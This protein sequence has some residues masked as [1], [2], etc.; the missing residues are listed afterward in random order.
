MLE[1]CDSI[2]TSLWEHQQTTHKHE[3]FTLDVSKILLVNRTL[4]YINFGLVTTSTQYVSRI[5]ACVYLNASST[6][7]SLSV[8]HH[9]HVVGVLFQLTVITSTAIQT[10]KA[11]L[12]VFDPTAG[13]ATGQR[14]VTYNV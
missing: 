1:S 10:R 13:V 4:L 11:L 12:L 3:T 14:L 7:E 6:G 8:A 9:T 5:L 2:C